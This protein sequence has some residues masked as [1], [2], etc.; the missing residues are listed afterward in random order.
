[1]IAGALDEAQTL[2]EAHRSCFW[3]RI[4]LLKLLKMLSYYLLI[5]SHLLATTVVDFVLQVPTNYPVLE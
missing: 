5:Y 4:L 2:I 1:M 3:A